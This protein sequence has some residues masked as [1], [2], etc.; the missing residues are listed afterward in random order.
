MS[1]Q[2]S[3]LNNDLA[4]ARFPLFAAGLNILAMALPG[5]PIL[6]SGDELTAVSPYLT[7]KEEKDLRD[8]RQ[9]IIASLHVVPVEF[10]YL[11]MKKGNKYED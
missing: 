2:V 7:W 3:P 11:L 4:A 6:R 5:L 8:V 10:V 9:Y 1:F